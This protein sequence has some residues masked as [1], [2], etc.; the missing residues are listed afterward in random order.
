[1]VGQ[2][3]FVLISIFGYENRFII[4]LSFFF[5]IAYSNGVYK[6]K[7]VDELSFLA[8]LH[9][10]WLVDTQTIRNNHSQ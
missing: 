10:L 5:S 3:D 2:F 6:Q 8:Y 9:L 1:M 4:Y 7:I